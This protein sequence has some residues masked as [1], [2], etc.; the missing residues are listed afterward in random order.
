MKIWLVV[1]LCLSVCSGFDPKK[2]EDLRFTTVKECSNH[3]VTELQKDENSNLMGL[4][5]VGK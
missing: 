3:L 5:K 2:D 1:W 4:C